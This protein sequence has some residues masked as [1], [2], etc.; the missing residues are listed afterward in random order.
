MPEVIK[1]ISDIERAKEEVTTIMTGGE[2]SRDIDNLGSHNFSRLPKHIV[3]GKGYQIEY[4][5][6][7]REAVGGVDS[8]TSWYWAPLAEGEK[9]PPVD[10]LT[11]EQIS[12]ATDRISANVKRVLSSVQQAGK[13]GMDGIYEL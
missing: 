5:E 1:F 10:S 8:G 3:F 7:V 9:P 13:E 12:F 2:P 4:L 11:D 6:A